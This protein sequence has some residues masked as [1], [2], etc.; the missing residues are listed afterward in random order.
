M[1]K[2]TVRDIPVQGKR[3]LLR[4]DF[5]VPLEDGSIG[6][7]SRIRGA[8]PTI[9][10]LLQKHARVIACSHLGQ[11]KG[12][13]DERL[14]LAPVARRLEQ[15]LGQPVRYVRDCVGPEVEQAAAGLQEGDVLL[16]DNLRFH[17]GEEKNDPAFARSLAS[18]ADLYVDDAFGAA[19]RAHA[20][21][22]G[23]AQYLPAVAG[24]LMKK[25]I[26]YLSHVLEAPERPFGAV[27]GGAKVSDKIGV[28]ERLV[29]QAD[30]LLIGGGMAATFLKA[31]GYSVGKSLLEPERIAYAAGVLAKA[32]ESGKTLLLPTDVVVAAEVKA[33]APSRAVPVQE[34]PEGWAIV[35]IGPATTQRFVQELR[36]CRTVVWNGP[37]GVFEVPAFAQGTRAVAE[38]MAGLKATTIVGGGSTA[39]AVEAMGLASKMSHVSTGGGASL[40]FLQGKVLPGIAALRDKAP[41]ASPG[42]AR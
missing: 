40:E 3:V 11:P 38:A 39:E 31:Q 30:A 36:R 10:Y 21:I 23:V 14:R 34:V 15:L 18:L 29:E 2:L 33:G 26:D 35:D 24:L 32:S 20:S 8:L 19:H 12:V 16:L 5:N 13:V 1:Q 28:L 37:M 9:K 17:L 6:D 42:R 27:I 41:S 7:D 4:V 22:A 25:E